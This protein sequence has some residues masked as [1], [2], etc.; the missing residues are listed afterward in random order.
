MAGRAFPSSGM[1]LLCLLLLLS[2]S[3]SL[4]FFALLFP[5]LALPPSPDFPETLYLLFLRPSSLRACLVLGPVFSL[6]CFFRGNSPHHHR[7][8]RLVPREYTEK[9][10]FDTVF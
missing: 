2:F 3:L 6:C 4:L 5:L 9:I 1:S 10:E 8:Y 7:H